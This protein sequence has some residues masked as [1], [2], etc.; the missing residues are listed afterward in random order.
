MMET[1][2][3]TIPKYSIKTVEELKD[4]RKRQNDYMREY[5]KPIKRMTSFSWDECFRRIE[6]ERDL[7]RLGF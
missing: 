6:N 7:K 3:I 5:F 4:F 1:R 2:V